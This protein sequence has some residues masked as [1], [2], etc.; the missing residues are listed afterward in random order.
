M[1]FVSLLWDNTLS[2]SAKVEQAIMYAPE[3]TCTYPHTVPNESISVVY[4]RYQRLLHH[5]PIK[6]ERGI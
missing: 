3:S 6:F 5:F 2:A 1:R 4:N